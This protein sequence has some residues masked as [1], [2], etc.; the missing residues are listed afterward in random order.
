MHDSRNNFNSFRRVLVGALSLAGVFVISCPAI[1]ADSSG[2]S[3]ARQQ[4]YSARA[5]VWAEGRKLAEA[6]HRHEQAF[7]ESSRWKEAVSELKISQARLEMAQRVALESVHADPKFESRR[8]A[9]ETAELKFDELR[10]KPG[11]KESEIIATA[12][13]L[14]RLRHAQ[15]AAEAKA[16]SAENVEVARAEFVQANYRVQNLRSANEDAIRNDPEVLATRERLAAAKSGMASAAVALDH[17][18]S[19]SWETAR[20]RLT[21]V[22]GFDKFGYAASP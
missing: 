8:V 18:A 7:V 14:L 10:A 22:L 1:A 17:A 19:A 11:V 2:V 13:Q 5:S 3:A 20:Q 4:V 15:S 12:N 6:R 9:I 16:L 21:S